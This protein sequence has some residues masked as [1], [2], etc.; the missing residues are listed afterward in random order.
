DVVTWTPEGQFPFFRLTE[1]PL[2]MPWLAPAG[3][4]L[5][6]VD[7]G[8]EVGDE[9]WSMEEAQLGELSLKHLEKIIPAARRRYLGCRVLR[10]PIAYPIFL[11]EYED[12]RVRL[13]TSTGVEGLY[14]IGRNG[15][16]AHIF[17][18]DVY[19]RTLKKVRQLSLWLSSQPQT[20][21]A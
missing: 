13:E 6:T 21:A 5:I 17:M 2:A 11:K 19:W 12:A 7:I 20:R 9:F 3:K 4:T 18:E 16:F 10:T 8:C 14:S 15:E 1:T